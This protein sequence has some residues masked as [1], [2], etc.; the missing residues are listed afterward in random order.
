M[1]IHLEKSFERRKKK[2]LD[3]YDDD[4]SVYNGKRCVRTKT[5]D[6]AATLFSMHVLLFFFFSVELSVANS[7]N[8]TVVVAAVVA[9]DSIRYWA[10]VCAFCLKLY[11]CFDVIE[12]VAKLD[13]VLE[14]KKHCGILLVNC[15]PFFFYVCVYTCM[16]LFLT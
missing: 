6:R 4:A 14:R 16:F 12:P 11:L 10:N 9:V 13:H 5:T 3:E 1:N 8:S 15:L 2:W 7:M